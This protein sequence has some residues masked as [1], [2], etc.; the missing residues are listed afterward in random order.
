LS[1]PKP[2][3]EGHVFCDPVHVDGYMALLC[4]KNGSLTREH[5]RD[6][7]AEHHWDKFNQV[8]SSTKPGN[9]GNIGFYF[10]EMEITPKARIG[11]HRYDAKDQLH[12]E[13]D[14]K[15][16]N[17]RAVIE[18][19]FLSMLLHSQKIGLKTNCILATG[20]ASTNKYILKIMSDVF[21][22][23]V[24]THSEPNSAAL[25]AAFRALHGWKCKDHFISFDEL[26]KDASPYTK[27]A[28]PDE[29]SHKIYLE[30]LERYKKLEQ[31]V[32]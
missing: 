7:Y 3:L 32:L 17:V 12:A 25:G 6:L 29:G 15:D 13:F 23:P 30:M 26:M 9:N 11:T 27:A 19:Q 24:Y 8:L 5:V 28:D 22:V 1:N 21:G 14:S 31:F 4:Y 2:S 20:G 10:K 16:L 18:S